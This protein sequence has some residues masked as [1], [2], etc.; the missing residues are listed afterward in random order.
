MLKRLIGRA[1]CARGRI[2]FESLEQRS[3]FS[4]YTHTPTDDLL[5]LTDIVRELGQPVG[6]VAEKFGYAV[7]SLDD[8]DGD[9]V[10]DVAVSAPGVSGDLLPEIA[11]AV[12]VFSAKTG[13]LLTTISDGRAGFGTTIARVSDLNG[14]GISDIIIGSPEHRSDGDPI[15]TNMGRVAVYSPIDGELIWAVDGAAG[16]R[17]GA[18]ISQI[19]DVDNDGFNDV[20]AGAPGASSGRGRILL[21]SG[22]DGS[23][24][25]ELTGEAEGDGFGS[26]V[27]STTD[28]GTG[29]SLPPPAEP[30]IVVGAPFSDAT[31]ENSGRAYYYKSS[32]GTLLATLDADEAFEEFG[33]ALGVGGPGGDELRVLIGAPG[34]TTGTGRVYYFG[35]DGARDQRFAAGAGFA[36]YGASISSAGD[37]DR[38]GINDVAIGLPGNDATITGLSRSTWISGRSLAPSDGYSPVGG[39]LAHSEYLVGI[40]DIDGD[41][42]DDF[43]AFKRVGGNAGVALTSSVSVG[44]LLSLTGASDNLHYTWANGDLDTGHVSFNGVVKRLSQLGG[45]TLR[46]PGS[47]QGSPQSVIDWISNDGVILFHNIGQSGVFVWREG[48]VSEIQTLVTTVVGSPAPDWSELRPIKISNGGQIL[49]AENPDWPGV[50]TGHDR[51]WVYDSGTLTFAFS[52]RAVD[53]N[54]TGEVVGVNDVET[55]VRWK[56]SSGATALLNGVNPFDI[57]DEG[58]V[59]GTGLSGAVLRWDSTGVQ[60]T[61]ANPPPP[62][63]VGMASWVTGRALPDGRA[64]LVL[65]QPGVKYGS[66][67]AFVGDVTSGYELLRDRV[68][69]RNQGAVDGTFSTPIL[70]AATDGRIVFQGG[71]LAPIAEDLPWTFD[72]NYATRSSTDGTVMAGVSVLGDIIMLTRSGAGWTGHRIENI[73]TIVSFDPEQFIDIYPY[74]DPREGGAYAIILTDRS[75]R[76]ASIHG[77][78]VLNTTGTILPIQSHAALITTADKRVAIAGVASTGDLVMYYQ[79]GQF[80]ASSSWNWNFANITEDHISESGQ[81][82]VPVVGDLVSMAAPWN[83]NHFAY[84]DAAGAVQVVWWAP[85]M[86]LWRTDNLSEI[87]GAGVLHGSLVAHV[88]A[89]GGMSITAADESGELTALWW[90]P[91]QLGWRTDELAPG[92][93]PMLA[94][95]SLISIVTPWGGMAVVGVN[96]EGGLTSFWWA[97]GR[98][99]WTTETVTIKNLPKDFRF[100]GKISAGVGPGGVQSIF[101]TDADGVAVEARFDPANAE[102]WVYDPVT[103]VSRL[104]A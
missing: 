53:I 43:A 66:F 78:S 96:E 90:A 75:T 94:P 11:G 44:G 50:P 81:Q 52:G 22:A 34:T 103:R 61:V 71:V 47:E 98:S 68:F 64:L 21:L 31:G 74:V 19:R 48:V 62:Q 1:G 6:V 30:I 55:V 51:V 54:A 12:F 45:F 17:L 23:V 40:G 24:L 29:A 73:H 76:F 56:A 33:T 102:G 72:V 92:N 20:L 65:Y 27:I 38:D 13:N 95:A 97:P 67:N 57:D 104:T 70:G 18:A 60:T 84:L 5:T 101:G 2:S 91:G 32:D 9:G 93:D 15:G 41:S 63:P 10:R 26:S 49:L 87:S 100:V 3:L 37:L 83:A 80:A 85:G 77:M 99:E 7:A 14:D 69:G 88:T 79:T 25:R 39:V 82:F 4:A 36:R 89:W 35:F 46:L 16:D 58:N 59:I 28:F 42:F 8:V 86:D